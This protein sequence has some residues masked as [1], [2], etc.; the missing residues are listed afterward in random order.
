[1]LKRITL[2][3]ARSLEDQ[4]SSCRTGS[5]ADIYRQHLAL[6]ILPRCYLYV[7]SKT[8]LPLHLLPFGRV[9]LKSQEHANVVLKG[10]LNSHS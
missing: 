8:S 9:G 6:H 1:M 7:R 4:P 5:S 10:I 3:I 2:N